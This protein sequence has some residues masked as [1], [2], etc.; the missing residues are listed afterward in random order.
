MAKRRNWTM[1]HT[2]RVVEL[3]ED[4]HET[5]TARHSK[6]ITQSLKNQAWDRLYNSFQQQFRGLL[7]Q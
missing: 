2:E 4:V 7:L 6:E 1:E 5:V 3:H